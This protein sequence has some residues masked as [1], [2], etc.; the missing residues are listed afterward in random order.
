MLRAVPAPV[1]VAQTDRLTRLRARAHAGNLDALVLTKPQNVRYMTGFS[2]STGAA[3]I[4]EA[5]AYLV[6]D[7]RYLEQAATQA[8]LCRRVKA[9]GPL[10]DAAAGV[11]R[12]TAARRIGV[13]A[14]TMPVGPFL[15]LQSALEPAE[16]IP[17]EGLDQLRWQKAPEEID[18]IRQAAAIADAAFAAVLPAIRPGAV[19]R[20][21]AAAFE[22]ELR[23]RGSERVPFDLIVA[24][25]PR[26]ALPHGVASDRVIGSGEFVTIDFGAVASGYNSDCTRTVVTA[27]VSDR[28]RHVYDV[29]LAAQTAALERVRAGMIG[30]EVDAVARSIIAEAGFGDAFGHSLGHG[31][32][33]AVHEG[34]TLSPREEAALPPGA[35]VS[36]EPGVYVPGWGGVR[37]EDLIVVTDDGCEV[38][39]RLSKALHEVRM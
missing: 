39:T 24:S 34:P 1:A 37:I 28:H 10:L 21:I 25:G 36:V 4:T 2:G 6:L 35:V 23:R 26:S 14:D 20:E 32:G 31:V 19:E 17:L 11:I 33:L 8:P 18:A 27:P 5:D 30:R 13:E 15:R 29:V 3:V 22:Y 38:L 12:E 7:F 16:V 9:N